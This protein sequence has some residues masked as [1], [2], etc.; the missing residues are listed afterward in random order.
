MN[1]ITIIITSV[2]GLIVGFGLSYFAG[3]KAAA[4]KIADAE[5]RKKS[6]LDEADK[7][8]KAIKKEK[9]LEAKEKYGDDRRTKIVKGGL[10]SMNEEDLFK[11]D[12][13]VKN[14]ILFNNHRVIKN[15]ES[16][17]FMIY[18]KSDIKI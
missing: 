16:S 2:V 6:I 17:K 9:L 3:N 4:A 5:Q 10:K 1:E 14:N 7:E 11:I 8:A 15:N 13:G 12:K 18:K